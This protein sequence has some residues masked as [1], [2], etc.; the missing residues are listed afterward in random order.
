MVDELVIVFLLS[1]KIVSLHRRCRFDKNEFIFVKGR[2]VFVV[3]NEED[4]V[5]G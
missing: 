4:T 2:F 5:V 1:L 3:V